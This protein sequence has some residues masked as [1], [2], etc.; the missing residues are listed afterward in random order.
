MDSWNLGSREY[1]AYQIALKEYLGWFT[2]EPADH[3]IYIHPGSDPIT[4]LQESDVH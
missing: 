4:K 2:A 1:Y 3:V